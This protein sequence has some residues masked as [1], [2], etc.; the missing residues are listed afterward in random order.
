VPDIDVT[1]PGTLTAAKLAD[2][3]AA[4]DA[5]VVFAAPAAL[6]RVAATA[7]ELTGE[8]RAAL[9]RIRLLMSAGAPVPPSLLQE[10]RATFPA[11]ES[12]TPYGMTEALPVTDVS[13]AEIE[14]AG[15]GDGVCV[16]RPVRGVEVGISPLSPSGVAD[17]P[18][19][20][21]PAT[22]GEVCVR[23]PHVKDRYDAL[24][25]T[26]RAAGRNPGW[27]RTGDVGHLDAEGRLWIEGRLTHV[28]TTAAGP[29]TPVGPERRVEQLNAVSA[30]AVVGVGPAGNQ[31]AVAVVVP[32]D[33]RQRRLRPEGRRAGRLTVA[34]LELTDDVRAAAGV[35]L[36]AVLVTGALPVDIRHQSKVDRS[37]LAR[38]AARV[39]AGTPVRWR[40][41]RGGTS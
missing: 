8:Q 13:L 25:V 21:A 14:A 2:A 7:G 1:A 34:P 9:G 40:P 27:H 38:R 37:A 3:A 31:V 10:L 33:R 36:A 5:T 6:R 35:D 39:L 26:E 23:G 4:V 18:L 24:W 29:L 17:G 32:T 11:A 22:T 19:T 28:V 41:R 20:D 30:A 15:A 16:G 12:H